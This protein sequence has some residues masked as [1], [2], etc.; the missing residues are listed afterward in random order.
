[1][2]PTTNKLSGEN[3]ASLVIYTATDMWN[4]STSEVLNENSEENVWHPFKVS[5][6][7]PE[8]RQ[9]PN[10]TTVFMGFR[11]NQ[12]SGGSGE[13]FF[14]DITISTSEPV[15][16][17]VTDYYDVLT[18]NT[19]TIMS[20]TYLKNLFSYIVSD[21]SGISFSQVNFEW[22]LIATD[23]NHE[24]KALN[25]PVTFTIIDSSF[26]DIDNNIMQIGPDVQ[27]M[28]FNSLNEILGAK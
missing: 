15:T 7:V 2:T 28:D 4:I 14:D 26:N 10:T 22:G 13:V 19:G 20:A 25:S 17:F 12:F 16:F 24:V 23:Q 11:Y 6:V 5:V 9:F 3:S 27:S 8:R 21:L 1:M 18:N